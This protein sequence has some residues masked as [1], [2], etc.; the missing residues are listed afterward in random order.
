MKEICIGFND[1]G[2]RLDRFLRKY[3]HNASLSQIYKIIRKDVKIDG[4]RRDEAYMLKEGEVMSLYLSDEDFE[5]FAA[6]SLKGSGEK[7]AKKQFKIV[8]E[9]ENILICD[10]PFGLL[11][12]GDAT[13]KKNHLANQVKDYLIERGDF[14]P[15]DEKVFAPA[16]ANRL[17]RNTTGLV[18]FGKNAASLK[19]LNQMIREDLINKY[20]LTIVH[21]SI[22][23]ESKLVGKLNKDSAINKVNIS[24]DD[25]VDIETIVRPIEKLGRNTTLVE[26]ELVTGRSHQIRAHLASIGHPII[27]DSKYATNKARALNRYFAEECGLST[28]LLHAY[29]LEIGN[30]NTC[31]DY[32]SGKQFKAELP[33]DF[34]N[35]LNN[36]GGKYERE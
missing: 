3:L 26:V 9:D 16:P 34:M 20:Y 23:S 28:Q 2:R 18:L 12:H 27:G 31:L 7:R 32:L 29:R 36:L 14:S 11:T 30:S 22:D 1:A 17:D 35:I 15:R 13:E 24:N 8:Y 21:G 4:K 5:M 25:G 10:K 19:A 33:K 6:R